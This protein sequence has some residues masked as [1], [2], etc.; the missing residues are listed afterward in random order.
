[1]QSGKVLIAGGSGPLGLVVS[2]EIY[3]PNS[4]GFNVVGN[5]QSPRANHTATL[6]T[7]GKVL[8]TGVGFAGGGIPTNSAEIYDPGSGAFTVTGSMSFARTG[9]TATLRLDGTVL[10]AGGLVLR[11][12]SEIYN[13]STGTFTVSRS[14]TMARQFQTATLLPDG[15]VLIVGGYGVFNSFAGIAPVNSTELSFEPKPSTAAFTHTTDTMHFARAFHSATLLSNGEVLLVG[16]NSGNVAE[17][18]SPQ[19]QP[20]PSGTAGCSWRDGDLITLQGF[21][22]SAILDDDSFSWIYS[23]SFGTLQLGAK[24]IVVGQGG[25]EI[26]FS[27]PAAMVSYINSPHG[28]PGPLPGDRS[29]PDATGPEG[30]FGSDVLSLKLNIDYSDAGLRQGNSHVLF[31]D[32]TLC[33]ISNLPSLQGTSVRHLFQIANSM[34]AGLPVTGGP[35]TYTDID[36]AVASLNNSFSWGYASSFVEQHL[37][38]GRCP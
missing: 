34:L 36:A 5:L 20:C 7:N 4:G 38:R 16:G 10:I 37:M 14:M 29:D 6:L 33:N 1:L 25:H 12:Q 17:L 31:G 2:A 21:Q 9:H 28:P 27:I 15:T 11:P 19:G 23:P 18:Y 24:S 35:Y 13:P 30:V 3:D 32:L 8:L 22:F 26:F